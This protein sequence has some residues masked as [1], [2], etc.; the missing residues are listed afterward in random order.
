MTEIQ[1]LSLPITLTGVDVLAKAKTGTGKTFCF[2]IPI[3]ERILKA[4]P[5]PPGTHSPIQALVISPSRELTQQS[6]K[7]TEKLLTFH[8]SIG[9]QMV[10]GGTNVNTDRKLLASRSCSILLATP[11]R[12]VEHIEE[13]PGFAKRLSG[14][15]TFV[16]DEADR[17]LDMGFKPQL[18]KII[19]ALPKSRQSLFFTATIP[20]G[21]NEIASAGMKADRQF[22]DAVGSEEDCTPLQISQEY[23]VTPVDKV[24]STLF[25]ILQAKR[26]E[27]PK[28][29]IIVFFQTARLVKALNVLF[30]HAGLETLELHSRLSQSQRTRITND[31][32]ANTGRIL[33]ASD[34]IARG[35]DYPDV[36][37][38]IQVG[39]TDPS[40]YEH[41]VGRTGRAGKTGE[42]LLLIST[43]ERKMIPMLKD[44]PI[45]AAE[46][47][48]V[49]TKGVTHLTPI[50]P[51]FISTVRAVRGSPDLKDH[52]D[53]AFISHLGS[54]RSSKGKMGWSDQFLVD[55]TKVFFG[56]VGM[57]AVPPIDKRTLGKMGLTNVKF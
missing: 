31:F 22:I 28:H 45:T 48:S 8:R 38:V 36:S 50:P 6:M 44:M 30:N 21:V 27:D 3:I 56:A 46:A 9:A 24:I 51:A 39:V 16:L 14:V 54:I 26:D 17:L 10:I 11:G 29:K 19:K 23:L 15:T 5:A 13:T 20:G 43:E 32:A 7:E 57:T 55:M 40:S 34:V 2:M 37:L 49:I 42:A 47:S 1:H 33:L 12:L 4:H 52:V 25:T 18:D 35:L 41:R 53:S